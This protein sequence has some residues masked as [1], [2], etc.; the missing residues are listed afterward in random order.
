MQQ[1]QEKFENLPVDLQLSKACDDAGFLRNVSFGHLFVT[2]HEIHLAGF[3][4]TT[5]CRE[6]SHPRNDFRSEPKGA[7]QTNT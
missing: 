1:H 7:V 4:C 2:M 3:G 6:Y 5:S